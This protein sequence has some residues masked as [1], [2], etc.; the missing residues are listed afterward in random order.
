MFSLARL[1]VGRVEAFA[2]GLF[3]LL[4]PLVFW[5]NLGFVALVLGVLGVLFALQCFR[6]LYRLYGEGRAWDDVRHG[7]IMAGFGLFTF[8]VSS[9]SSII[10]GGYGFRELTLIPSA[11]NAIGSLSVLHLLAFLASYT[12]ILAGAFKAWRG[13]EVLAYKSRENILKVLALIIIASAVTLSL[14]LSTIALGAA[15]L[16]LAVHGK[17]RAP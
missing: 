10:V 12:L 4:A 7:F 9:L 17:P 16:V 2:G 6:V 11:V 1:M 14:T 3:L 5:A 15:L 13:L 8:Y